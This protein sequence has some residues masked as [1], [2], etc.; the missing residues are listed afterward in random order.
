MQLHTIQQW[1]VTQCTNWEV[2]GWW[3]LADA[4]TA[5]RATDKRPLSQRP[6]RIS[7]QSEYIDIQ[8][9]FAARDSDF[10]YIE[11]KGFYVPIKSIRVPPAISRPMSRDGYNLGP[12]GLAALSRTSRRRC[13]SF[14]I[15]HHNRPTDSSK[16]FT[17]LYQKCLLSTRKIPSRGNEYK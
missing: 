17:L 7:D 2:V 3:S 5:S 14:C 9:P 13:P 6:I 11:A 10:P 16:T 15:Y 12:S 8:G 1:D 4:L